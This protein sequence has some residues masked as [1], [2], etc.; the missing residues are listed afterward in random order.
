MIKHHAPPIDTVIDHAPPRFGRIRW[1]LVRKLLGALN[2]VEGRF[3]SLREWALEEAVS[4]SPN[5]DTFM[6]WVTVHYADRGA[7]IDVTI[8]E[9]VVPESALPKPTHAHP[10]TWVH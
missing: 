7:K 3:Q 1:F 2:L 10:S 5:F 4:S 6:E 8:E 9:A